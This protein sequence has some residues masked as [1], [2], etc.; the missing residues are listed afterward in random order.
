MSATAN[1]EEFVQKLGIGPEMNVNIMAS[2][3]KVHR[4]V[5]RRTPTELFV[6]DTAM[7]NMASAIQAII[8][9]LLN[10]K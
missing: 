9:I 1:K 2:G 7:P 5:L 6:E 8:Q 4:Y 10:D 3:F